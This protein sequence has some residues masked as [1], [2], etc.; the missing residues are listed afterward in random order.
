MQRVALRV[1]ADVFGALASVSLPDDIGEVL[2]FK[3][4]FKRNGKKLV[5]DFIFVSLARM[6]L[7]Y[8]QSKVLGVKANFARNPCKPGRT[9]S[10]PPKTVSPNR[11]SG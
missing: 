3:A 1:R 10:Q 6:G 8:I 2:V 5:N 4:T 7:L 11:L 9:E